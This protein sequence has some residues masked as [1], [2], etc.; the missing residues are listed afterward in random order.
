MEIQLTPDQE[1][2][3]RQAIESGRVHHP[4]EAVQQAL[5]L[6]EDRERT[7]AEVLTAFDEAESDLASG[8][9]SDYTEESLPGL[10]NELKREARGQLHTSAY[11]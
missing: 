2:F 11:R 6:W 5:L 7:R 4:E 10:G 1:A 9:F 8:N 3:V